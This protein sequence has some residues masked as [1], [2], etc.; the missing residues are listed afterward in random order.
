MTY[1]VRLDR[2]GVLTVLKSQPVAVAV[3]SLA[4]NVGENA[5]L[6]APILRHAA[7]VKVEHY[8]SDRAA[9]AVVI[10]HPGGLGIQAK[11]GTLTRAASAI[12]LEVRNKRS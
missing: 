9:S 10:T 6:D 8:V 4:E 5:R 12:G 3:S 1:K 7:P 11:Y 2:L